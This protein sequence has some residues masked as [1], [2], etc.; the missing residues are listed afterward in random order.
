MALVRETDP[1]LHHVVAPVSYPPGTPDCAALLDKFGVALDA[2]AAVAMG[3]LKEAG[4][5]KRK[6]IVLA[7][8]K[9]R[10]NREGWEPDAGTAIG[11]REQGKRNR[12]W[13]RA[14]PRAQHSRS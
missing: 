3:L 7:A 8:L 12:Q 11:R 13:N 9:L 1:Y 5:G 10:R 4:Q 6:A 2:T 14:A